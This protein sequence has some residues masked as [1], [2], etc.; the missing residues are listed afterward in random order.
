MKLFAFSGVK[1]DMNSSPNGSAAVIC[2]SRWFVYTK[3]ALF[4]GPGIL[5]VWFCA[6]FLIPKLVQIWSETGFN[7]PFFTGVM[8]WFLLVFRNW[9]WAAVMLMLIVGVAEWRSVAWP[10]YRKVVVETGVLAGNTVILAFLTLMF[11]SAL[12][13]ASSPRAV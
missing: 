13:A 10:K 8:G 11:A 12:L 9:L 3:A 5:A 4:L 1:G 7:E 6:I 2:G